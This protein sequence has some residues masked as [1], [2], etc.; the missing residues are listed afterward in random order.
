MI[1]PGDIEVY[2][3]GASGI[4][5]ARSLRPIVA[6]PV[7]GILQ[8]ACTVNLASC[9]QPL[10][11]TEIDD[12][13]WSTVHENMYHTRLACVNPTSLVNHRDFPEYNCG[14]GVQW[15]A[16]SGQIEPGVVMYACPI[17]P[18]ETVGLKACAHVAGRLAPVEPSALEQP[19]VSVLNQSEGSPAENGDHELTFEDGSSAAHRFGEKLCQRSDIEWAAAQQDDP[20]AR[21]VMSYVEVECSESESAFFCFRK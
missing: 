4:K 14:T 16:P 5:Q 21:S 11:S 2:F 7:S 12:L 10:T 3:V 17:G 19:R 20:L 13:V 1:E 18:R 6:D 9:C 15:L 8:S